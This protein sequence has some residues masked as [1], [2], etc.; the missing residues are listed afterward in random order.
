MNVSSIRPSDVRTLVGPSVSDLRPAMHYIC[1]HFPKQGWIF[2]AT[3]PTVAPALADIHDF[4]AKIEITAMGTRYTQLY[5]RAQYELITES[6]KIL[7]HPKASNT[8]LAE[9]K[10]KSER[11]LKIISQYQT[12]ETMNQS[13][14]FF[15]RT[16]CTGTAFT[17][18]WIASRC[19]FRCQYLHGYHNMSGFSELDRAVHMA[20]YG[21]LD[22]YKKRSS[23][24]EATV[25]LQCEL[26][27]RAQG[28]G[29]WNS[30]CSLEK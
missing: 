26:W 13:E 25:A 1:A 21:W 14:H 19:C 27:E 9:D 20:T 23:C 22:R 10:R 11:E 6:E 5:E 12:I 28:R 3:Q 17:E 2:G 30:E 15:L 29:E 18:R 4:F 24:A 16:D 8:E 7:E